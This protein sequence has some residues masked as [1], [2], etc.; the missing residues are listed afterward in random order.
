MIPAISP[1]TQILHYRVVRKLGEGGM[2]IVFEA[3]DLRLGRTVAIKLLQNLISENAAMRA[4]FLREARAASALDHPNLCTIYAAEETPEGALMLVMACYRGQTLAELLAR[5]GALEPRSILEIGGQ[6]AAGLHAAHMSGVVHRD[7][8]PGNV[9]LV[10]GGGVKI[11]DFGLSRILDETQLTMSRHVMGTLA[12]MPP[13]QLDGNQVDHRAD[14]WALGAVLYEMAAGHPPFRHASPA[15]ICAAISRG[16]YIPLHEVRPNLPLSL[17]KAVERC[18]RVQPHARHSSAAEL[19]QLLN[20]EAVS[21]TAE[22]PPGHAPAPTTG[23]SSQVRIHPVQTDWI[24]TIQTEPDREDRFGK[25]MDAGVSIAV[26]PMRNLSSDPDSE[27]FSDGLTEELIGALGTIVGLRVVSR[28]S[29]FAFRG[30]TKD[31]R[32]IGEALQ[33]QVILEGSV[34]RSGSRV[35][36]NTQLT[37]ARTG[38]HLWS[39]PRFDREISDVFELQDEIASSVASA[40]GETVARHLSLSGPVPATPMRSEAYEAYL[41]GRYHWNRKTIEDI[42]LAG[43]YFEQAL[44]LDENSAAAHAGL[45][46]YYCLQGSLGLMPPHE[47]WSLARSSALKAIRLD[48]QLP[49]GHIALASVLQFYDWNWE[50]ARQHLVKAIELRPQRGDSYYIYVTYLLIHGLLEEALEQVRIGLSYDPLSAPLLAEEAILRAYMGDHDTSILLAQSALEASPHYFELYYALGIAQTQSGRLHEAVQTFEAG[51]AKS[52]MPV[53][54]G[55]L[56]EA[57]M[58]N[59]DPGKARLVL[60]QLLDH[61]KNGTALPVAIAVAA[62]S[63]GEMDLAFKWLEKAAESKDILLSYITVLPSLRQLHDD[64]RYHRLLQRMNLNHPSTHRRHHAAR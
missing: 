29:A 40:L 13:E 11:L 10:Q 55:W 54:M 46:D 7:I 23:V 50:D 9:F 44:Q 2:G 57:H 8:K 20:Q 41:K 4:R 58:Q 48:P 34:R 3:E 52:H 21:E 37:D 15:A 28:T 63:V 27:Y 14:I 24:S 61:E 35:R 31:I 12:Y 42:Q 30:T 51:I 43:R 17:M 16:E 45:A 6:V 38:F 1:G 49:E 62:V 39:S 26:L 59:G 33:A 22:A 36:V 53:L 18:L 64:P 47:A 60:S 5:S 25:T 32:E 19:L 56:A